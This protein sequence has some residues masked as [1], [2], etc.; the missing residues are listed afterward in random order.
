MILV[1]KVNQVYEALSN[2][3]HEVS[4]LVWGN[5]GMPNPFC[6][7]QFQCMESPAT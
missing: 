3:R 5:L 2:L 7:T 1:A 4:R 6:A